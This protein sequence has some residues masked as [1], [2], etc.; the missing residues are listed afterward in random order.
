[1]A[2]RLEITIG[3]PDYPVLDGYIQC[4]AP[5]SVI[6]GPRGSGK[7]FGSSQRIL[8]Q[9]RQ[10]KP[11]AQGSRPSRWMVS[12]NTYLD[13]LGTTI[14][15]FLAVFDGLGT[16][17]Y[18]GNEPPTFTVH[19]MC[20][21][22]TRV[23]AEV[24]FLS[25]DREDA[26]RKIKGYQLTGCWFNEASEMVKSVVDMADL[27]HG[28]YPR[29]IDGGVE[30]TWHGMMLDT[31]S[32][33]RDHWLYELRFGP[34]N[35]LDYVA[36]EGWVWFDQP[37][38]LLSVG[39]RWVLN[40]AAE[41][42]RNLV[43]DY[44]TRGMQGKQEDWIKVLLANEYGFTIDGKAVHPQ[45]QDSVHCAP[46]NL[47]PDRRYP[48]LLGVDFG[49]TPAAAFVQHIDSI[50]R[51]V[52]LD[53]LCSEDMSAAIF[54]PE[55]KRYIDRTY[56]GMAVRA[57][58]DPAGDGKGQATEDTPIQILRAAGIPI[59]AAPSNVAA[60][61]R[62]AIAGPCMR[63]CMDGKP[64][65]IV[66]PKAK[67]IRKGLMG[68]YCYRR[69]KVAGQERYTEEP[70]KNQYSHPVEGLEYALLGAGEGRAALRPAEHLRPRGPRQ[71]Y[72][73]M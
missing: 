43:V 53:E 66:S 6:R 58:G 22:Q 39:N 3:A 47:E 16:M 59:V 42:R 37:G 5:N 35:A 28:R 68:G 19:F 14:K 57:W 62:A 72:A 41:N 70:D 13:L 25:L 60:L 12:R 24:I 67:R 71:A 4:R 34:E 20:E 69:L 10:Q 55:L 29:P 27:A 17:K 48:L 40:P 45:Y 36:P 49:R 30:A 52:V 18:G 63:L 73:I 2:D 38:G 61:R 64:A 44:Y 23:D 50:G 8:A 51:W 21:D 31:N 32:Y 56:P 65:F 15:D 11:N 46:E 1:V 9:M 33:D 26:A 7:T 54:G